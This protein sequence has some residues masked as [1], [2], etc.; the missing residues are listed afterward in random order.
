M[1]YLY[2]PKEVC[3]AKKLILK[4]KKTYKIVIVLYCID[5]KNLYVLVIAFCMLIFNLIKGLNPFLF[6][7]QPFERLIQ[8]FYSTFGKVDPNILL[9]LWKG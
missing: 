1:K 4:N 2:K 7:S 6:Y 3:A 8:T 9:N 5:Y